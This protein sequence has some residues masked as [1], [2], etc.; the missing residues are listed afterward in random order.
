MGFVTFVIALS[1][2]SGSGRARATDPLSPTTKTLYAFLF[3][4]TMF[5][6]YRT[7]LELVPP[8]SPL[9]EV[10]GTNKDFLTAIGVFFLWR[11]V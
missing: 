10:M 6:I 1:M 11:K 4:L 9:S 5:L 3:S 2:R 7:M 8:Q